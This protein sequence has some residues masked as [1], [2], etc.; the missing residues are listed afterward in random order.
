V[1][2]PFPT[3]PRDVVALTAHEFS[4][5]VDVFGLPLLALVCR[6]FPNDENR[7][8]VWMIRFKALRAWCAQSDLTSWLAAADASAQSAWEVAASFRLN[9]EWEFDAEAFRV[10]VDSAIAMRAAGS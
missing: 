4:G 2:T 7:A 8:L 3:T 9:D 5:D 10:A 1:Q 6:R